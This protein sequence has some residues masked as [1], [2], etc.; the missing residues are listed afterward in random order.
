MNRNPRKVSKRSATALVAMAAI[1]MMLFALVPAMAMPGPTSGTV[2]G[3]VTDADTG[4]PIE[5]AMVTISYHGITRL[6]MTDANGRYAFNNVPL[7]YCLKNISVTKKGYEDQSKDVG[8]GKLTV[9]DFE[10]VPTDG[11]GN[12]PNHGSIL[13]T[14]FHPEKSH[15]FGL[16]VMRNFVALAAPAAGAPVGTPEDALPATLDA[17]EGARP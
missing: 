16:A 7:C 17:R 5:D 1:A 8:V 4:E 15:R 3:T 11:G 6:D 9:V 12:K 14:Q 10:L 2:T 13:G